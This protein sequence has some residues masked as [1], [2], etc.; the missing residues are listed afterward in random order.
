M[1]YSEQGIHCGNKKSLG[2][3][4]L[5]AACGERQKTRCREAGT[6]LAASISVDKE[7]TREVNFSLK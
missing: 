7:I 4:S 5:M 1:L 6:A 2:L 3:S